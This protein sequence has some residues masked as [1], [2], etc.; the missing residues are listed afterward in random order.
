MQSTSNP[1]WMNT[2]YYDI[3]MNDG[4]YYKVSQ[5]P[6]ANDRVHWHDGDHSGIV[7]Y[8]GSQIGN[9]SVISKYGQ[10]GV[11]QAF[12]GDVTAV[13]SGSYTFWRRS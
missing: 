4:S 3:Y 11:Y 9:V 12:I 7:V 2:P 8:V 6:T 1:Y 13:Y 10:Y 5:T